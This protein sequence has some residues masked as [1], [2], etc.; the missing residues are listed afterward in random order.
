MASVGNASKSIMI[1][2]IHRLFFLNISDKETNK[3]WLGHMFLEIKFL[4]VYGCVPSV[5][6]SGTWRS[7]S[8]INILDELMD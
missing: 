2:D 4:L 6:F 1:S 8:S 5:E 7:R 3:F